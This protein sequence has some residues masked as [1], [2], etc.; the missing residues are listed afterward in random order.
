M[1]ILHVIHSIDPRSGGPSHAI[2]AMVREQAVAGH[3]VTL[4][5]TTTQSGEPWEERGDYV[6]RMSSELGFEDIE[7]SI[8]PAFGRRRPWSRFAYSPAGRRFLRRRLAH[9]SDSRPDVVHIHGLFSDLTSAAARAARQ[10]AVPYILRPAGCLD[11]VCVERGARILKRMFISLIANTDLQSACYLQ[12]TSKPEAEQLARFTQ[13]D[14]VA[15]VPHGVRTR[16][17]S[18]N[19]VSLW[20]AFPALKNRRVILFMARL[21]PI[22]RLDLVL[23]A[24]ATA[25][26]T[27]PDLC[28]AVAGNDAGAEAEARDFVRSR[29]IGDDVVFTGFLAG[30]LKSSLLSAA[31]LYVLPSDHENFGVAVIEAMAHG[32]P[33]LVTP[34]VASREFVEA[35]GCGL[36][37]DGTV[38]ALAGGI[39]KLL[40]GDRNVLGNRGRRY[41]EEHL[42]WPAVVAQLDELYTAAIEKHR[43]TC[44]QPLPAS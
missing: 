6:R 39:G 24:F 34:G 22:K 26:T 25:R 5:T 1:R 4:L 23:N 11:S 7:L 2:R 32:T 43:K 16:Y 38:E 20:S 40:R 8:Q 36:T 17:G 30:E 44:P 27:T 35:S 33:V 13:E 15:T 18:T 42:A 10:N 21:H 9:D 37:V 19:P 12:A 3:D 41:V 31:E 28:L 29:N 14:N